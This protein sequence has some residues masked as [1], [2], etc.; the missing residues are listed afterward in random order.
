MPFHHERFDLP[1][2]PPSGF[3]VQGTVKITLLLGIDIDIDIDY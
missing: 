3:G 1:G 2:T